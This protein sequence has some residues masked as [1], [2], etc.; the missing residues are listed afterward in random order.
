MIPLE[1]K[2]RKLREGLIKL[3]IT[4]T[5]LPIIFDIQIIFL[6]PISRKMS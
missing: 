4:Q 5:S 2:V 3:K 6:G 1:E